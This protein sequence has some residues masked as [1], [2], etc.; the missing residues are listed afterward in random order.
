MFLFSPSA[1]ATAHCSDL[2]LKYAKFSPPPLLHLS[3]DWL[4]LRSRRCEKP[5]AVRLK[6]S[7]L[8]MHT[9]TIK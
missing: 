5:G 4:P 1:H 3:S 9:L 8:C 6:L 7:V 2:H